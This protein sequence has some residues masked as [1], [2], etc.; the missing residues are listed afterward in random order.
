MCPDLLYVV[1]ERGSGDWSKLRRENIASKIEI[2]QLFCGH[3]ASNLEQ[4]SIRADGNWEKKELKHMS[5]LHKG[6]FPFLFSAEIIKDSL[7]LEDAVPCH[8]IIRSK[9]CWKR[10]ALKNIRDQIITGYDLCWVPL[11][12]NSQDSSYK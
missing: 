12:H 11:R 1:F 10:L 2:Q 9:T 5:I 3:L 4:S 8:M 7:S 6:L